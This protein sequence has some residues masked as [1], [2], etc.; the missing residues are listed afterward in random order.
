MSENSAS[1]NL[2]NC[3]RCGQP[4]DALKVYPLTIPSSH[5]THYA[6]C[7]TNGEPV[8]F[9]FEIEDSEEADDGNE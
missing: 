2:P 7:P 6:F 4:H 1:I 5:F 8:M 9:H 3:G